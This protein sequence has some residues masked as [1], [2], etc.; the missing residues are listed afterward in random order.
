MC[1]VSPIAARLRGLILNDFLKTLVIWILIAVVLVAVFDSFS[2]SGSKA[3]SIAYSAFLS[4]VHQGGITSITFD[5][6][7]ITGALSSGG[8]FSTYSPLTT[9]FMPLVDTL[10]KNNANVKI[11]AKPPEQ[12]S[13]LLQLLFSWGPMLLLVG[14]WIYFMRQMSG[15]AGGVARCPLGRVVRA[16]WARIR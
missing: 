12:T 6:R 16:C 8:K 14:V 4:D 11:E 3:Q 5:G 2:S 13:W 7:H 1:C 10:R 15:G 9:D